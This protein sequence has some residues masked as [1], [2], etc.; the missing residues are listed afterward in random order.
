MFSNTEDTRLRFKTESQRKK[1][2][3]INICDFDPEF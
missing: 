3:H 2:E 1:K